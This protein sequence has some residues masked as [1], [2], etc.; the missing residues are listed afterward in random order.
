MDAQ[1]LVR[2]DEPEVAEAS[3]MCK[4]HTRREL[5][6]TR[7]VS[8]I[9]VRPV[10]VWENWIRTITR[11][12]LVKIVLKRCIEPKL[13]LINQLHHRVSKHCFREGCTVHNGVRGE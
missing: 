11:Q 9:L 5:F 7:I 8:Q 2:F 3:R 1:F 12:R 4:A 13:A 10:L 6:P